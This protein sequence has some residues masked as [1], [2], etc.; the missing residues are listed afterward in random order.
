MPQSYPFPPALTKRCPFCSE[1]IQAAA[2]KCRYCGE[3]LDP[4]LIAARPSSRP[5]AFN[6]GTAMVLS[7]VIPGAGQIYRGDASAGFGWMAGAALGYLMLIIPGIVIHILCVIDAGKV[8]TD[9]DE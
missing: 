4:L 2:K 7:L 8:A 3:L 9:D 6:P 5:V 1:E